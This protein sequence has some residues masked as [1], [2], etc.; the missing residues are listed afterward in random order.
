MADDL[1]G[2][3]RLSPNAI[4]GAVLAVFVVAVLIWQQP[5][6]ADPKPAPKPASDASV[7]IAAQFNRLARATKESDFLG[8]AGDSTEGK[9]FGER[10]YANV[11]ALGATE[12]GM[13]FV[14]G[15]LPGQR[16]DGGTEATVDVTWRPGTS[17]GLSPVQTQQAVVTFV[18]DPIQGNRFAIRDAKRDSGALPLWLAGELGVTRSD[19]A[20]VISI[21]GGNSGSPIDKEADRAHSAVSKVVTSAKERLVVVSPHT[22]DQAAEL[23]DQS[24][25]AI[26]QIAAVTTTLDASSNSKA[27]TVIVLNPKV[28]ATM[29]SRAAQIVMSHE[30]TH[31]MTKAA[32]TNIDTWISEGFADYVALHDDKASLKVSA[33]QILRAVKKD[34]APD[35]LPTSTDFGASQHGLGA[36]YESAWMIFRM[37]GENYGD[38]HVLAFYND[39]LAGTTTDKAVQKAFGL[40][41]GDITRDWRAYLAEKSASIT[42]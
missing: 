12:I 16:A 19:G 20:T 17:S 35:H 29:D 41:V 25:G 4:A 14:S 7:A 5:W 27:A 1:V 40:S 42:S 18:L 9:T 38:K 34:G 33:G 37:L 32:M 36:T 21:D 6:H 39:V 13:R 11:R 24:V 22:Q 31:M 26:D 8:A 28:F 23:L 3:H 2:R 30:A 15:G 10:T